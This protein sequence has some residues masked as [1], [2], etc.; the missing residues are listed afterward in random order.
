[1]TAWQPAGVLE[2]SITEPGELT[3]SDLKDAEL[4]VRSAFGATFRTHDW[5]HGIDGV[6]VM[7]TDDE[8]LVA[9]ASVAPRAL[10][11]GPTVFD[12]G[13][14]EAVAVRADQQGRGLGRVVMDHAEFVIGTRHQLGALNAVDTAAAFYAARGWHHWTGP[15]AAHSPAGLVDTYDSADCIFVF[16]APAGNQLM[17]SRTALICDWRVGDLW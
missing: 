13:Y 17:D 10:R 2:V 9:H 4:L 1:M 16:P 7:I 12:T 8:D 3:P 11:H 6:H 15:T 5:Q 14:V